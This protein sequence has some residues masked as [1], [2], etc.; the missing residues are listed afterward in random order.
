[1]L[2][3][4]KLL[5]KKKNMK[6]GIPIMK[7][8]L[9]YKI[10]ILDNATKYNNCKFLLGIEFSREIISIIDELLVDCTIIGDIDIPSNIVSIGMSSFLRFRSIKSSVHLHN[11]LKRIDSNAFYNSSITGDLNI[12]ITIE[13]IG[14]SAFARCNQL[15]NVIFNKDIK[16]KI[17]ET[18]LFYECFQLESINIPESINKIS[19]RAFT[20]CINLK[21]FYGKNVLHISK[22]IYEVEKSAFEHCHSIQD[23]SIETPKETLFGDRVFYGCKNIVPSRQPGFFTSLFKGYNSGIDT[24]TFNPAKSINSFDTKR[25]NVLIET[26]KRIECYIT[27]NWQNEIVKG[28]SYISYQYTASSVKNFIGELNSEFTL[29]GFGCFTDLQIGN[30]KKSKLDEGIFFTSNTYYIGKF[31]TQNDYDFNGIILQNTN[32]SSKVIPENIYDGYI[33]NY[34]IGIANFIGRKIIDENGSSEPINFIDSKRYIGN[35]ENLLPNGHGTYLL[36]DKVITGNWV[37]G[38]LSKDTDVNIKYKNGDEYNGETSKYINFNPSGKGK[39]TIIRTNEILDGIFKTYIFCGS[40]IKRNDSPINVIATYNKEFNID[41]LYI[42]ETDEQCMKHG[43]GTLILKKK[44]KDITGNWINDELDTKRD[45]KVK[46]H[47]RDVYNGTVL[48]TTF[49]RF[50]KG[51]LIKNSS[52]EVLTGIFTGEFFCGSYTKENDSAINAVIYDFD[53]GIYSENIKYIG[54]TNDQCLAHGYGTKFS[55]NV[56]YKSITGYWNNDELDVKRNAEIKFRNGNVYNGTIEYLSSRNIPLGNGKL[57]ID[58]TKEVLEGIF[59]ARYFCGS[60]IKPNDTAINVITNPINSDHIEIQISYIGETNERCMK[61]GYGTDYSSKDTITGHWINNKL[62]VNEDVEIKFRNGDVYKGRVRDLS[63]TLE[64]L[65]KG[66]LFIKSR[67]EV[68]TGIFYSK[69]RNQFF[70]GTLLKIDDNSTKNVII[71]FKSQFALPIT[72]IYI[73]QTNDQC[74]AHGHGTYFSHKDKISVNG[75]WINDTLDVN[76][77][78][79][80]KYDNGDEYNGIVSAVSSKYVPLGK[81]TLNKYSTK[82]V[83]TGIFTPRHFCGSYKKENDSSMNVIT[84]ITENFDINILYIGETNEQCMKHGRGTERSNKFHFLYEITGNWNNNNLNMLENNKI[85]YNNGDEYEGLVILKNGDYY[86]NGKGIGIFNNYTLDGKFNY[87]NL[88]KFIFWGSF[89]KEELGALSK[90]IDDTHSS[91][92]PDE[93]DTWINVEDIVYARSA[94][95]TIIPEFTINYI[96]DINQDGQKHGFGKQFFYFI[97]RPT[98]KVYYKYAYGNWNKDILDPKEDTKII[99]SNGIKYI[100]QIYLEREER[101]FPHGKGQEITKDGIIYNGEFKLGILNFGIKYDPHNNSTYTG[102]FILQQQT[103]HRIRMGD[104]ELRTPELIYNG[105][106]LNDKYHGEGSIIY[107]GDNYGD[108]YEGTFINGLFSKGIFINKDGSNYSGSWVNNMRHG[109][110]TQI[111]HIDNSPLITY[112]KDKLL[113]IHDEYRDCHE[114]LNIQSYNKI[115][116]KYIGNWQNNLRHGSGYLYNEND[117]IINGPYWKDDV[118]V[119]MDM[120]NARQKI[121][122]TPEIVTQQ[123]AGIMTVPLTSHIPGTEIPYLNLARA[124]K[125]TGVLPRD[126]FTNPHNIHKFPILFANLPEVINIL[127]IVNKTPKLNVLANVDTLSMYLLVIELTNLLTSAL[128]RSTDRQ[129]DVAYYSSVPNININNRNISFSQNRKGLCVYL[130][131]NSMIRDITR[132]VDFMNL[133][134]GDIT[135]YYILLL[136]I[137]FIKLQTSEFQTYWATEYINNIINA[138]GTKVSLASPN[139]DI[140]CNNGIAER[141][142]L[143]LQSGIIMADVNDLLVDISEQEFPPA[144]SFEEYSTNR[145]L[146]RYDLLSSFYQKFK[147]LTNQE[148]ID[149]KCMQTRDEMLCRQN[150]NCVWKQDELNKFNKCNGL[151]CNFNNLISFIESEIR[152]LPFDYNPKNWVNIINKYFGEVLYFEYSGGKILK[153]SKKRNQKLRKRQSRK[154]KKYFN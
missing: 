41:I 105:K 58:S 84:T 24:F 88:S 120:L 3:K 128:Q 78:A 137:N 69:E 21:Y 138:S 16:L 28:L 145:E 117:E 110:G 55:K 114:I 45:V 60:Y 67:G 56:Y 99:N 151:T 71:N 17:I 92:L 75:H 112:F 108:K 103:G 36:D 13:Y 124:I 111:Y 37:N 135:C 93:S 32:T 150:K 9:Y 61:H 154:N 22:N 96:G 6:G 40:Y 64:P 133:N 5:K 39:L 50:G 122:P 2:N 12:P 139:T 59:T 116:H 10:I 29:D 147:N 118:A 85:R 132:G 146:I 107:Q 89:H 94:I 86:P 30:F 81:G 80:I 46:Y 104:G 100:G 15:I 143:F 18:K 136:S 123:T 129:F 152:K 42:G 90:S 126:F 54:E 125:M 62:D 134:R 148:T 38:E 47:N 52:N 51:E 97:N 106:W 43:L 4:T 20:K 34:N 35:I 25:K 77:D 102:N 27:G 1:M 53:L 113:N 130:I 66:E 149:E 83:L 144:I 153:R 109:E 33:K 11:G 44:I 101:I 91:L 79:L 14:S 95:I 121:K 72:I 19:D 70:C 98:V 7:N 65:G 119:D 63:S 82:E 142:L 74:G 140:S 87:Q 31:N 73:G 26:G 49:A 76:Q 57:Y 8:Q 68:L 23:I 127:K 131:I 141:S 115:I 48:P